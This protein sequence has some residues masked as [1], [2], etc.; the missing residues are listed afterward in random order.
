M[1]LANKAIRTKNGMMICIGCV[2]TFYEHSNHISWLDWRTIEYSSIMTPSER[3]IRLLKSQEV[4]P[5]HFKLALEIHSSTSPSNAAFYG[6]KYFQYSTHQ[7]DTRFEFGDPRIH[8]W[9]VA[10]RVLSLNDSRT[11][12]NP[13]VHTVMGSTL[14]EHDEND[15]ESGNATIQRLLHEKDMQIEELRTLNE[16]LRSSNGQLKEELHLADMRINEMEGLIEKLKDDLIL[17]TKT[18]HS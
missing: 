17:G 4:S 18:V 10:Q 8:G 9:C 15:L 7:C 3:A 2:E 12:T 16:E 11:A 1:K 5:F 13:I 6:F 14:I